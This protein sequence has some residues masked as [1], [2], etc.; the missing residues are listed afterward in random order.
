MFIHDWELTPNLSLGANI[1]N[2]ETTY[3]LD[4]DYQDIREHMIAERG[5][6][7]YVNHS[8]AMSQINE[9][10][11]L[12]PTN[13]LGEILYPENF[14][15]LFIDDG[16]NLVVLQVGSTAD[17]SLISRFSEGIEIQNVTFSFNQI[18]ETNR[19][20][21]DLFVNHSDSPSMSNVAG[22]WVDV[23]NNRLVVYLHEYTEEL[24]TDFKMNVIDSPLIAF[25]QHVQ[26]AWIIR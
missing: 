13:H 19:H 12:L 4:G 16:G 1:T 9:F 25:Y 11:N 10:Y 22:S 7:F 2:N 24:I 5:Y 6:D 23:I 18:M 3:S 20:L 14:G 26:N 15:G 21:T 17:T 8:H